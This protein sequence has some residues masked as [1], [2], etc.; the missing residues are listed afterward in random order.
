M[1]NFFRRVNNII[2]DSNATHAKHSSIG[3]DNND[4]GHSCFGYILMTE[5]LVV[6]IY[7]DH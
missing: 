2:I 1:C 7:P 5:I 4:Q 6:N 3:V